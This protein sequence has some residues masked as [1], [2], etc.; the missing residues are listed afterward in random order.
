MSRMSQFVQ[1]LF[2]RKTRTVR[3]SPARTRLVVEA[4]EGRVV[5]AVT[6]FLSDGILTVTGTAGND[7]IA[8]TES[9]GAIKVAGKSFVADEVWRVVVNG[10]GGND[11]ITLSTTKSGRVNG[12]DGNDTLTGGAGDDWLVGGAG[13]DVQTGGDGNDR[14][15]GGD[16]ADTLRGGAGDDRL[17]AGAGNDRLDGGDGD[18]DLS[19]GDGSDALTG[20]RG[21]DTYVFWAAPAA[22]ADTVAELANGGTDTLDFTALGADDPVAA[23]LT[24]A[25]LARHANRTVKV[26]KAGQ[27]AH[28]ENA[29]GGAGADALTGNAADNRLY[30][31]G[32]N[33]TLAGGGGVDAVVGED[34][35]D[36][37]DGG[38]AR[39]TVDGG[40]GADTLRGG[41]GDDELWGHDGRDSL[42]GGAG[43]DYLDAGADDDT[44]VGGDG[45]DLLGGNWGNDAGYGGAGADTLYGYAGNDTLFGEGGNDYFYGQ[46][47]DDYA[48]GGAGD[49][50]ATGGAGNDTLYGGPGADVL[51]GQDGD[52]RAHGGDD[53]DRV[54][55]GPGRDTLTGDHGADRLHGEDGDDLLIGGIWGPWAEAPGGNDTLHGGPGADAEYGGE[56]DDVLWGEAGDDRLDGGAGANSFPDPE[57]ADVLVDPALTAGRAMAKAVLD[58]WA[59]LGGAGGWVGWPTSDDRAVNGGHVTHFQGASILWSPATGAREVHGDIRQKYL[60]LGGPDG[61]LGFP[62]TD[63][64]AAPDGYGRFNHFQGGSVYWTWNTKAHVVYGAIRD[65]W[66]AMGWERSRLGYPTSDE[67][68]SGIGGRVSTFT[69]G[70]IWWY[71]ADGQMGVQVRGGFQ[72]YRVD[73]HADRTGQ[74]AGQRLLAAWGHPS[75]GLRAPG[76]SGWFDRNVLGGFGLKATPQQLTDALREVRYGAQIYT[77]ASFDFVRSQIM[78]G[79]PVIVLLDRNAGRGDPFLQYV[80]LIGVD[81]HL[82]RVTY[83][84]TTGYAKTMDFDE[85][86]RQWDWSAGGWDGDYLTGNIGVKRR[87]MIYYAG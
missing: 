75:A 47:G 34:G 21:D 25:V 20:G 27:Q 77:F 58:R 38:D 61:F 84:D 60:D 55:G 43:N 68:D 56:G 9:R 22:E 33:D 24:Q 23:D 45:D 1:T 17:T 8:V 12:G 6:A 51:F 63:E 64:T 74:D 81:N 5:P 19:G 37:A 52:D 46:D 62:L 48:D 79:R 30:G 71:A 65:R 3:R 32:G 18:D 53:N 31:R 57:A 4:L 28:V 86:Y 67:T 26:A 54:W 70:S 35:D 14:L 83:T 29:F 66:A 85:F 39:D 44:L 10:L 42:D 72:W 78:Y 2:G 76:G 16:G 82:R 87:T 13:N 40:A 41:A 69:G 73:E 36:V 50:T 80:T 59:A 7:A 49:D 11:K 15:T